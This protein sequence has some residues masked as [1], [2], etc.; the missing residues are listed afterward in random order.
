VLSDDAGAVDDRGSGVRPTRAASWTGWWRR[1]RRW[2]ECSSTVRRPFGFDKTRY[3]QRNV[4][5]HGSASSDTERDSATRQL[6]AHL[7]D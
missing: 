6:L 5:E 3:Q 1:T 2:R 7:Q 4:V